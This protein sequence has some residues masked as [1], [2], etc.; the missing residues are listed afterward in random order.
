LDALGDDL[1]SIALA[2]SVLGL[3]FARRDAPFDV[4]LPAFAE[5]PLA[6]IGQPSKRD[7]PMP[8][9]A[10][11]L[12][13]VAVGKPPVVAS[14]KFA[15]FCPDGRARISGLAPRL[16]IAIALLSAIFVTSISFLL[17]PLPVIGQG[18]LRFA[19][20]P[21]QLFSARPSQNELE[22][23]AQISRCAS[24]AGGRA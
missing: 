14:E 17:R 12:G 23:R 18:A 1:G 4:N 10:L 5:E 3:I 9:G 7:D 15:T 24:E 13:A 11:L 6:R 22:G 20:I 16:P 21:A 19:L 2:A 8:V